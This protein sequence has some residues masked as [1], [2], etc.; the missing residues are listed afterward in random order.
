MIV[1]YFI[2]MYF[3][4]I[5]VIFF[6]PLVAMLVKPSAYKDIKYISLEKATLHYYFHIFVLYLKSL[7]LLE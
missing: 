6:E 2:N 1:V 5:Y 4:I 7:M 3:L